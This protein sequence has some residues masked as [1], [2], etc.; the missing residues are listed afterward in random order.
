MIR[1]CL[2]PAALTL[3]LAFAAPARADEISDALNSALSAYGEGDI[4]YALEEL[5]FAK[6]LLTGLQV[7]EL[8]QFLPEPPAGY[9]REMNSEMGAGL[10]L[11]GGGTG[12]EAEYS[13]GDDS[14]TITLIAD[15]PMVGAMAGMLSNAAAIG[16]KIERVGR[17]KMMVQDGE[18]TG[19]VDNRILV[20]A[21]GENT[22]LMLDVLKTLDFRA[23]TAFGR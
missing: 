22:D 3:S 12:A 13:N 4:K 19:L 21:Q 20:Q 8:A 16:A 5:E 9:S 1:Q 11:M 6:R 17:Q 23:L 18:I 15:N 7:D 14:F 2:M 10:S